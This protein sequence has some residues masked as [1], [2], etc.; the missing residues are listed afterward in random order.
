MTSPI[1]AELAKCL[2]RANALKRMDIV[3]EY[4]DWERSHNRENYGR[5]D[6]FR[7]GFNF[8]VPPKDDV[9]KLV[10]AVEEMREALA[11]I[12]TP[13][14]MVLTGEHEECGLSD[15]WQY[16]SIEKLNRASDALASVAEI[17]GEK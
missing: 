7:A 9:Q 10:R 3:T 11:K 16:A 14:S 2:E 1:D 5:F 4:R 13:R 17:L 15:F 12:S 8:A 6:A